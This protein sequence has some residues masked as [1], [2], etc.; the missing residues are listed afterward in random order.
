MARARTQEERD[1][2]RRC[3]AWA[4]KLTGDDVYV[5]F[6]P[7][8]R[9]LLAEIWPG[10]WLLK[11]Y[12]MRRF[13]TNPVIFDLEKIHKGNHDI[14]ETIIHECMHLKIMDKNPHNGRFHAALKEELGRFE[15]EKKPLKDITLG[16]AGANR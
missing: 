13:Q 14:E 7:L 5:I 9:R 12:G 8:P 3:K 4:F 11:R 1:I 2:E 10:H 15:W 16:T 6:H